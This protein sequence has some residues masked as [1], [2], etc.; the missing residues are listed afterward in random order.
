MLGGKIYLEEIDISVGRECKIGRI[1]S[2]GDQFPAYS[3]PRMIR[4]TLAR[5][6]QVGPVGQVCF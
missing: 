4:F 2:S 1:I 5:N 3:Y 6:P